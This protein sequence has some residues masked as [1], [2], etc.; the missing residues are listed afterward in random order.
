[1][2]GKLAINEWISDFV[3]KEDE[4]SDKHRADGTSG[5]QTQNT[6]VG[7]KGRTST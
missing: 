6:N 4:Y 5:G 2:D 1:M 7:C 3:E